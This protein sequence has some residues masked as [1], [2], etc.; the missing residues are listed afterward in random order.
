MIEFFNPDRTSAVITALLL[1]FMALTT[2]LPNKTHI[3]API[4]YEAA[5]GQMCAPT[6][7]YRALDSG[8]AEL[9]A[10]RLRFDRAIKQTTTIVTPLGA[11]EIR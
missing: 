4:Q 11:D 8:R 9:E 7:V 10:A 3:E 6:D 5:T 1:L 2:R